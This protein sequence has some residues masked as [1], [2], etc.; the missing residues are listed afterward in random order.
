MDGLV[1]ERAATVKR[2]GA[3]PSGVAVVLGRAIPLHAGIDEERFAE[4]AVVEPVLEALDVGLET[5][6]KDY[7]E[8]YVGF[9]GGSDEGVGV[10]CGDVGGLFGEDVEAALGCGDALLGVKT[11]GSADVLTRSS[12][13]C[14][15][16]AAKSVKGL[17]WCS[18]ARRVTVCGFVP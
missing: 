13:L 12:G 3:A 8:L 15:R 2:K 4:E 18:V 11:G 6:L 5:I 1:D 9:V 17:A 14:A 7:R 16:K 10:S